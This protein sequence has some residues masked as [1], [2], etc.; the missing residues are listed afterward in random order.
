MKKKFKITA[1]VASLV[2]AM[3]SVSIDVSAKAGVS[4]IIRKVMTKPV[5]EIKVSPI[6]K[7]SPFRMKT[8]I[9]PPLPEVKSITPY[10]FERPNLQSEY[11]KAG[12]V[13]CLANTALDSTL[14]A[15]STVSLRADNY[16]DLPKG[17]SL[18]AGTDTSLLKNLPPPPSFMG[19]GELLPPNDSTVIFTKVEQKAEYPGG[20]IEMLRW[21]NTSL[22][23]PTMAIEE[24][25]QGMVVLK[26]VIEK[27]GSISN[28][29]VMR[30]VHPLLDKEA[31]R[32]VKKLPEK[33]IPAKVGGEYV[34]SYMTVPV[35]F[36]LE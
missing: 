9:T 14:L 7:V 8:P 24:D 23:Y 19:R 27:D 18:G 21:I 1:I 6:H 25:I 10:V 29:K 4:K 32:V 2:I 30:G 12:A 17:T 22:Y 36:R 13:K 34:R 11:L 3:L 31:M 35:A 28:V 33:F 5:V 15:T 20:E 16:E 26:F